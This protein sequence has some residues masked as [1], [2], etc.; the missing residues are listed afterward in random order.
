VHSCPVGKVWR[1]IVER[2]P[3]DALTST[4]LPSLS[5]LLRPI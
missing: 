3:D 1:S 5:V 2:G 4:A